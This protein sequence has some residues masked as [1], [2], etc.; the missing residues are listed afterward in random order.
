MLRFGL[1]AWASD[2]AVFCQGVQVAGS[3]RDSSLTKQ[4]SSKYHR[5]GESGSHRDQKYGKPWVES[6]LGFRLGAAAV[7][8]RRLG[9]FLM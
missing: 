6:L 5:K 9:Y 3:R 7:G 4:D 2:V 8:F 1:R